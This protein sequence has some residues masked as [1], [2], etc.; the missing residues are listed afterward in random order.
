MT[1]PPRLAVVIEPRFPGGTSAA[2]TH[3]LGALAGHARIEVHGV[4]SR[5]FGNRAPAPGLVAAL[6][7]LGLPLIM[8]APRIAA[9]RVVLHNPAFLKFETAAPRIVARDI[10][11]VLHENFQRPGGGESFDVAHCLD[12]VDRGTVALRKW[13]APISPPNRATV[14]AWLAAHPRQGHWR[15]LPEDWS[16]ICDF[17]MRPPTPC[18]AD[19]RGRHSRPGF[20]KF[21]DAATLDLCFPPHAAANVILGADNL[22]D[23][24]AS[25]PH[26]RLV[27]FGGMEVRAYFDT[28]DFLVYFTAPTFRESFGRV[29]AEAMAAGKVVITDPATAEIFGKGAIGARPGEVDAI[30]AAHLAEPARYM[31]QARAGQAA[32]A[33]FSAAA[34]RDRQAWLLA[35]ER[36][37]AA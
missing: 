29:L 18:P 6:D 24:G 26:W 23:L 31:Q 30:V 32:L 7:R 4:T 27:P 1:R 25:R 13:L 9:E 37:A 19:R 36:E 8:D 35:P 28:I 33:A 14:T 21:P 34:F 12:L 15:V 20:E 5:M 2:V 17:P 11:L 10:V 22:T 16:N 3:E